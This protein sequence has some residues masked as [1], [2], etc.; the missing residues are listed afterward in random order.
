MVSRILITVVLGWVSR[1]IEGML[2]NQTEIWR[3]FLDLDIKTNYDSSNFPNEF[4]ENMSRYPYSS[5]NI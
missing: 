4:L 5:H 2:P 1:I 3:C